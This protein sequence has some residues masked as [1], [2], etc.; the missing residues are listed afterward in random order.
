VPDP[1][2]F[3]SALLSVDVW[4]Y[5][6]IGSALGVLFGS[7]PGFTATMGLAVLTPFT[8][9][10]TA[11]QALAMLLGLLVAAVFSGGIPAIL[12][13]TPGTP[14]SIAMTWDGYP[15]AR[16]GRADL[17]L[18]LNAIAAFVG[19]V[20]SL[21]VLWMAALPLAR[22]ALSFG[23]AEYFAVAAFGI[24]TMV[25]VSGGSLWK[26]LAMGVLGLLLASI[27]LDAISGYPRFTFGFPEL[28]DGIGFIPVMV[29][30]FG[31]AEVLVQ[32][33]GPPRSVQPATSTGARGVLPSAAQWP[34]LW[35]PTGI[36]TAIGI[37]I[38]L[39]PAAGADV[40]AILAWDQSRRFSKTPDAFGKGSIEGVVA[41]S[42]GANA[43]IGGALV[44]T[45]ALGIPGD[46]AAAVLIGALLMHGLQPGPL[47]FRNR[48]GLVATIVALVFMAAVVTLVWGLLGARL[49][50]GLLRIRDEFL[51]AV[52]LCI[53]LVGSYALN[54]SLVDVWTAVAAGIAGYG[55]RRHGF[56]MGPLVLA[57]ILGP[58]AESELRRAL[59]LSQGSLDIFVTRPIA[60]A[61][62][63]LAL[64]T[65][66][67]PLVQAGRRRR[68]DPA[69]GGNET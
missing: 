43:G 54:Q 27:G 44:T 4:M 34:T 11:D 18:G 55:L 20:C 56:P 16:S 8:F 33:S 63:V 57:L 42:T 32:M 9:W 3:F 5:V 6:V 39:V 69:A 36:G 49:L 52:V 12:L 67:W 26:G 58:M 23:P 15:L 29:G 2:V 48:P 62:L 38:G 37:W 28:L 7:L 47:L 22:V 10:V 65:F 45:L 59:A 64:V 40:G 41:A 17:A 60:L 68:P 25:G 66:V 30:L 61:F 1:S 21:V 53:S 31:V 24:S 50:A 51:W 14:A 13:N 35:R 46:S 19:I